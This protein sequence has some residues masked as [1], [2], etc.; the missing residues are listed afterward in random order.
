MSQ[1]SRSEH[2][3]SIDHDVQV[4]LGRYVPWNGSWP[5]NQPPR[6]TLPTADRLIAAVR[7]S[8]QVEFEGPDI[9]LTALRCS[10]AAQTGCQ[11]VI[12]PLGKG[13]Y[14]LTIPGLERE[15]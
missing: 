15:G 5:L 11:P 9:R 4:V 6:S 3:R 2:R 13:R 14:R 8:G 12:T 1:L 10:I 7:Q